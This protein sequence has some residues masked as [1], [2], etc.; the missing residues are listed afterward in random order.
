MTRPGIDPGRGISSAVHPRM[1][2]SAGRWPPLPPQ[3]AQVANALLASLDH[4]V[5]SAEVSEAW[6]AEI[7]SRV[8]DITSGRLQTIPHEEVKRQLAEDR[9]VRQAARKG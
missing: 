2:F 3:R 4:P 8:D 6:T 1:C 5:D 7:K 9:A